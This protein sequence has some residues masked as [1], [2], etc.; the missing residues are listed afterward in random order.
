[1]DITMS[2]TQNSTAALGGM[3]ARS[4]VALARRPDLH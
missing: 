3:Q 2:D 1:M 4:Q